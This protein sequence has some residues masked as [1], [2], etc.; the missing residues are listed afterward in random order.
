M[1]NRNGK[2]GKTENRERKERGKE[3]DVIEKTKA[4]KWK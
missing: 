4:A 1:Y 2:M 3:T